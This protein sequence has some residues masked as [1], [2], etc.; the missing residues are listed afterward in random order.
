M[1]QKYGHCPVPDCER[2]LIPGKFPHGLCIE[3]EKWLT[4]LL[5]ILPHIRVEQG[6][7]P[8]GLVLPGQ[9]DFQVAPEAVIKQE[10]GKHGRVKL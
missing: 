5:F 6:K 9:P 3:H 8:G 10:M 2:R 7:T 1:S 4:F